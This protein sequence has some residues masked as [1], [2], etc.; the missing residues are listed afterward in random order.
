MKLAR[1]INAG[2]TIAQA[3][4]FA[5]RKGSGTV[6]PPSGRVASALKAWA[7][8][9]PRKIDAIRKAAAILGLKLKIEE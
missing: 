1:R 8:Q 9:E 7:L 6:V 5:M 4:A 3:V 2:D